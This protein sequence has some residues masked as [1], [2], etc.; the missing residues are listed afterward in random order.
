MT[1]TE[2]LR[3]AAGRL[4]LGL[5]PAPK[6]VAECTDEEEQEL[7]RLLAVGA[8]IMAFAIENPESAEARVAARAVGRE[9]R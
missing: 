7:S 3:L 6:S 9:V 1:K 4:E 8:L 2:L 5:S